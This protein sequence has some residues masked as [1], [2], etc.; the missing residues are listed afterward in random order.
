MQIY[1]QPGNAERIRITVLGVDCS[2]VSYIHAGLYATWNAVL[3][4]SSQK[5]FGTWGFSKFKVKMRDTTVKN[6]YHSLI[7]YIFISLDESKSNSVQV[8]MCC[9]DSGE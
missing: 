9:R 7:A 8:W 1:T 3:L 5:T 6:Q 4:S 2:M